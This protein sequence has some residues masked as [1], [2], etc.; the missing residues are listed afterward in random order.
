MP[1]AWGLNTILSYGS[2]M[3]YTRTDNLGNRIGTPNSGRLPAY[4]RVDMRFVKDFFLGFA[5]DT[6][7][8]FFVEVEN[9]FDRR[10]IINVYSNTGLPDDDGQGWSLSEEDQEEYDLLV[11]DPQNF[12]IPRTIRWGFEYVF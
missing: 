12:D 4:Y 5:K 2:G 3:P 1:S 11:K 9:L 10:N 7:L 8:S 6:R